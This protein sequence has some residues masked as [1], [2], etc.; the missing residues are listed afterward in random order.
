MTKVFALENKAIPG[1]MWDN[2]GRVGRCANTP[3]PLAHLIDSTDR[4]DEMKATRICSVDRCPK[5]WNALGL[6]MVHYRRLKR[7]GGPLGYRPTTTA[8][9]FW[10]KVALPDEN[11]CMLWQGANRAALVLTSGDPLDPSLQAAHACRNRHCAAPTHL[12]WATLA[13]NRL[14]RERDGT[15]GRGGE[16]GAKNLT[17]S[18]VLEIRGRHAS[19]ETLRSLAAEYG[20]FYATIQAAVTGRTWGWLKEESA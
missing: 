9:R 14:D 18:Q 11:G 19:G 1:L 3:R 15:T 16:P 8:N 7:Y 6:C 10:S 4:Q 5:V 17:A 13:E 2:V 12:R 20:A